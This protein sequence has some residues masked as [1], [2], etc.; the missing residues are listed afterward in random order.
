M[1]CHLKN[2]ERGQVGTKKT[3]ICLWLVLLLLL[4]SEEMGSDGVKCNGPKS[5]TWD[6]TPCWTKPGICNGPCRS[7]GW[8]CGQ[9]Q[10]LFT[11]RCCWEC[12]GKNS[13]LPHL[14]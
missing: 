4:S 14:P 6:N 13:T 5:E 7:E 11:C 8:D 12:E 9:C 2:N 10:Q 1:A 3:L